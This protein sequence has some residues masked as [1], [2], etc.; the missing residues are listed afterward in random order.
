[1][2]GVRGDVIDITP[3]RTKIMEIGSPSE[4][5][6]WVH[7]RQY[8][9]RIVAVS[10]KATFSEPVFNYSAAFEYIREEHVPLVN[11]ARNFSAPGGPGQRRSDTRDAAADAL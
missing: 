5:E 4:G 3:L 10:N 9:G 7:G 8:T 6:S 11:T 1:M 2:G